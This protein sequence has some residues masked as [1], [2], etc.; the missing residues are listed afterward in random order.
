MGGSSA[1]SSLISFTTAHL[2]LGKKDFVGTELKIHI[3]F[4]LFLF[5]LV[6]ENRQTDKHAFIPNKT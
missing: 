5:V 3:D 6:P 2:S 1:Q 4:P